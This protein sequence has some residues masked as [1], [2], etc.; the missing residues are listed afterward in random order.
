MGN[1]MQETGR[2]QFGFDPTVTC[3]MANLMRDVHHNHVRP[4]AVLSCVILKF[5]FFL[6]H[7]Q[8]EKLYKVAPIFVPMNL[9][10]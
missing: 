3:S 1:C 7:K 5:L 9:C 2:K 10:F 8:K 6:I 4:T